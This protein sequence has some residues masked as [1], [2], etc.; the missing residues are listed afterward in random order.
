MKNIFVLLFILTPLFA[1]SQDKESLKEKFADYFLIGATINQ[2][3]Y[4]IID[5]DKKVKALSKAELIGLNAKLE[6]TAGT[7]CLDFE[8]SY[9]S[10]DLLSKSL[11][12]IDRLY[13]TL[14]QFYAKSLPEF[15]DKIKRLPISLFLEQGDSVRINVVSKKCRL[16]HT[17]N[18]KKN[19]VRSF[20]IIYH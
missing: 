13:L 12:T 10:Y 6:V 19:L 8:A 14:T 11:S 15:H 1:C 3:D 4:Q 20:V 5:K 9:K 16:H 7:G 18:L 17:Q 2:E